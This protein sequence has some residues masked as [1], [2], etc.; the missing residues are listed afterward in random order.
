MVRKSQSILHSIQR[1]K[2]II[3]KHNFQS[4]YDS[5]TYISF[6]NI[7]RNTC[8]KINFIFISLLLLKVIGYFLACSTICQYWSIVYSRVEKSNFLREQ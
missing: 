4:S 6:E 8:I 5:R 7:R 1:F 2:D 3:L